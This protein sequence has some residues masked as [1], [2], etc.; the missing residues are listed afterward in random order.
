MKLYT[1]LPLCTLLL[2]ACTTESMAN[3]F[4]SDSELESTETVSQAFGET[5]CKTTS[6]DAVRVGWPQPLCRRSNTLSSGTSYNH[7]DCTSSFVSEF[8]NIGSLGT[9]NVSV[10]Y[11]GSAPAQNFCSL[12]KLEATVYSW[13][14]SGQSLIN[15]HVP[16]TSG[17]WNGTSCVLPV[18]SVSVSSAAT[19]IRVVA[20]AYYGHYAVVQKVDTTLSDSPDGCVN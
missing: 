15:Q 12:A 9:H 11:K 16:L 2:A 13:N 3:D 8:Q 19:K 18:G 14:A 1:L 5:T 10:A 17:I 20:H 4:D 7:S 6:A